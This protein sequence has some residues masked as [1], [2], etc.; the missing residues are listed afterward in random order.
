MA[1]ELRLEVLGGLRITRGGAPVDFVSSKAPGLLVYLAVSG[2]QHFRTTLAA[3]LWSEYPEE[4]ARRNLRV[5]L[6]NLRQTLAP[7]L[8]ITRET[9]AFDHASPYWLDVEQFE[10][11]LQPTG[12]LDIARLRELVALYHGDFLDGFYV[13]D[14]PAFEEWVA[15]QRERLRQ[16]A[17]HALHILAEHHTTR[18]E[19][20]AGIDVLTPLLALDPWREEAHRQLMLLL[21]RCGQRAA[22]LAQYEMCRRT[23]AEELGVEPSEET[24]ELYEAIRAGRIDVQPPPPVRRHNLAVPPTPL[25]GRADELA[26]IVER[27]ADPACRL[28]TLVGPGGI[29]KTRLAL[30]VA[31]QL[32]DAFTDGVFFVDLTSIAEPELVAPTIAQALDVRETGGRP[33]LESLQS[34]LRDRHL[35]LVLDNFEQIISAAPVVAKLVAGA[36]GLTM[37]VTSRAPLNLRGEQEFSV[38]PLALPP[39]GEAGDMRQGPEASLETYAAVALFVERARVAQPGFHL[40]GENDQVVAEI[41]VRLDGLPLAIEL[42]AARTRVLPLEA[43]LARLNSRLG[44]LTGGPRDL[45]ARHQTLRGTIDWSYNL[46]DGG[47]KALFRRLAVF[48]GNWTLEAAEAVTSAGDDRPI[49]STAPPVTGDPRPAMVLDGLQSLLA[50]SLLRQE[51]GSDGE[52]RFSMYDTIREYALEQLE[53][54]GEVETIRRAH[55]IYYLDLVEGA[56]PE[57]LRGAHQSVWYQR[58]EAEHGNLRSALRWALEHGEAEVVLRLGGMLWRF[59]QTHAHLSEGRRWLEAALALC[60]PVPPSLRGAMAKALH[61]AGALAANLRDYQQAASRLE[62]SLALARELN[63]TQSMIEVLGDLGQAARMQGDLRQAGMFF[64]ESLAL[65]TEVGDR[66]AVEWS[67]SSLGAVAYVQGDEARA[68]RLLETSL[69]LAREL[70]GKACMG[71]DLT[72]LGRVATAQGDYNQ[73]AAQLAEAL[74]LF[75]ELRYKDAI[76]FTLEGFAG[77]A[78]ASAQAQATAAADARASA[79]HAARLFGAGEV[80]R[81]KINLPMSPVDRPDYERDVAAAHALLDETA[82]EEAWAEGRTMTLEQAVAYALDGAG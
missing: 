69:A 23:L 16:L 13:R 17:I 51:T 47:D 45:P 70:G 42:A 31:H 11:A 81:E 30:E 5:V 71:W 79:L 68:T 80:L 20:A 40:T 4:D 24:T 37:L 76:A 59:W 74:T 50:Q 55:A 57:L 34:F 39:L 77:L 29:G 66:S 64:E 46:L 7:H 25:V 27:L 26:R 53:E 21:A 44:L 67:L 63:D 22:A 43:L 38:S 73:A 35:L 2:R 52:R 3:L 72:F 18:G 32:L 54:S 8:L 9:I 62:Q 10:T 58:L 65:S 1:E 36:R 15:M 56:E 33:L 28:L 14:A 19:Y 12:R 61:G 75:G 48:V 82:F 49:S 60:S 6:A 78:V 41:C